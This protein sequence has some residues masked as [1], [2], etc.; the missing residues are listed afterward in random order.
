[1]T[2]GSLRYLSRTAMAK[3]NIFV[4]LPTETAYYYQDLDADGGRLN[5]ANNYAITFAADQLPPVQGFWSLTLY[6][7]QHFFHPNPLNRYSL[8]TK[9]KNLQLDPDGSLTLIAGATEPD[10][11]NLANNWLPA[12]DDDFCLYLRASWP[13]QAVLDQTWSPPP[14]RQS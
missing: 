6:N 5:G 7:D 11:P 14:V 9:N 12:P 3:A 13:D 8:G 2:A 1:M 10:D 4:N